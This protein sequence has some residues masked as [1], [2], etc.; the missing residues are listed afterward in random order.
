MRTVKGT[1]GHLVESVPKMNPTFTLYQ[2]DLPEIKKWQVGKKYR[3]EIEVEMVSAS[4]D[5]YMEKE[6]FSARFKVTKVEDQTAK[7]IKDQSPKEFKRTTYLAK[8]GL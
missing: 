5:E 6:P 7:T 2:N 8:G 3:L 4:K 1:Q